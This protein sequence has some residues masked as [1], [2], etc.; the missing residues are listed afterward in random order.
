MGQKRGMYMNNKNE[1]SQVLF[2]GMNFS[3]GSP[4]SAYQYLNILKKYGSH[5]TVFSEPCEDAVGELYNNSFDKVY[6]ENNPFR[7]CNE[8]KLFELYCQIIKDYSY[9]KK[10]KPGFVI[11]LGH[12]NA[13]FF[14]PICS[15]L[16]IK[17]LTLIAGGDIS[18]SSFFM[19]HTPTDHVICF[20]EENKDVLVD[21]LDND[22]ITVISNRIQLKHIFDDLNTHYNFDENDTLN[23]LLT[24]RVSSDKYNSIL[25]FIENINE[26]SD[27]IGTSIS[28]TIA[29]DGDKFGDLKK[30]V[31]NI[32]NP[33]LNIILKGHVDDLL[34]EF[35]K[36]HIVV[37]KGRSVIEPI[38]MNRIGCVIGDDG[39]VEFCSKEN[40]DRLYHYNFSG[41]NLE[42]DNPVECIEELLTKF[43]LS[44]YDLN[45][46]TE[47][48]EL[49][50][51][52]YSS[53]FL[54]DKFI[55]VLNRLV[56]SDKKTGHVSVLFL[57]VK[58]LWYKL[59]QRKVKHKKKNG[60]R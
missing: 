11:I 32:Q 38:M 21:Y 57:I 56:P 26:V 43:R 28:L 10:T 15:R 3:G 4:K 36:A 23:I 31:A 53:E 34:P 55:D 48:S 59:K 51:M 22:R 60:K 2:R 14:A 47:T 6:F 39:K 50:R 45:S 8:Y 29:G 27:I 24:S 13:F 58:L 18:K 20:S 16:N 42:C 5:I 33:A 49:V 37:G 1:Y 54:E 41:R 17:N 40:F 52:Y 12:V 30:T 44:D 46:I 19:S 25:A 7:L 35:E 9:I